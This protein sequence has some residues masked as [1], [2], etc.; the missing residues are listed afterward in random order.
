MIGGRIKSIKGLKI[1]VSDGCD[2]VWKFVNPTVGIG[3][4][5]VGDRIWWQNGNGYWSPPCSGRKVS[6]VHIGICRDCSAP[7]GF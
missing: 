7:V 2:E 6:S 3:L 1:L 4:L 5:K